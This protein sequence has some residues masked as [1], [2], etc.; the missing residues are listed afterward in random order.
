M[1]EKFQYYDKRFLSQNGGHWY[2]NGKKLNVFAAIDFAYS[3]KV[4]A[5]FTSIVVIGIDASSTIYILDIDRFKTSRISDYFKAILELH[6]KWNF[7]KL[8]A[9]VTA[10]QSVIVQELKE[11]HIKANGLSL[12]IE[13]HRPT[14]TQGSKEERM[15]AILEPRYDN[16]AVFHY[17]GGNCELLE[18]ELLLSNPPHDDVKDALASVI[19]T[20]VPPMAQVY[21]DPVTQ[22]IITFNSRFGGIS[23]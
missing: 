3:T 17:K 18:E 15:A 13:E 10:A 2:Y 4:K 6:I 14:R 20:A 7:R 16:L 1:R 19:E 23:H 11:N 21:R 5:D 9:E 12:S 22:N 8:R